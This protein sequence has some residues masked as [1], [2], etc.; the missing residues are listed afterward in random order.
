MLDISLQYGAS[1]RS[2]GLSILLILE[3]EERGVRKVT[4]GII[5]LWPPSVN[6]DVAFRSFAV[7]SS[8]HSVAEF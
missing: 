3:F 5:D 4:R 6:D 2:V 7:G 8:Y 1:S